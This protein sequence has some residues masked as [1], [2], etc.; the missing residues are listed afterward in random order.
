MDKSRPFTV[1][2]FVLQKLLNDFI[3]I[4][5]TFQNS[6]SPMSRKVSICRKKKGWKFESQ[7]G[8]IIF[9]GIDHQIYSIVILSPYS[10]IPVVVYYMDSSVSHTAA[11][12]HS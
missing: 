7:V 5:L 1:I 8:N 4:L 3:L 11:L 6:V 12:L 10:I 9:V 2:Y